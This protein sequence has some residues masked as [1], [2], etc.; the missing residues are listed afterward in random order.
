MATSVPILPPV[1]AI[2]SKP[3]ERPPAPRARP[4]PTIPVIAPEPAVS[5]RDDVLEAR[6]SLI[7]GQMSAARTMLT[8]VQ[9]RMV[10]Q[11][12]TPDQP[13][14]QDVNMMATMLGTA[15]K[16]LDTGDTTTAV[17]MVNQLLSGPLD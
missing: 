7:S 9:T 3:P 4:R 10:L 17:S 15:I 12:V 8:R 13:D 6:R 2:P 1:A 11:P 14:R 5:V 16:A